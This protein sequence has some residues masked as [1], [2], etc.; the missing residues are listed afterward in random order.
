MTQLIPM[1]AADFADFFEFACQ[2]YARQNIASGRWP[3]ADAL[4][5]ARDE[6]TRLLPQG[7]QTPDQFFFDMRTSSAADSTKFGLIWLAIIEQAGLR[8]AYIYNIYVKE[9]HRRQ[10]H[11]RRALLALDEVVSNMGLSQIGLHVFANNQQAQALY[12]SLGYQVTG[13]NMQ[14][15]LPSQVEV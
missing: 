7:L 6:T 3:A 1:Q 2:D 10:G 12:A 13:L 14:K 4:Q 9:E 5:R 11:A 8:A 15:R